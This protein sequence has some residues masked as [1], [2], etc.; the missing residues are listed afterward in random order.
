MYVN[1]NRIVSLV[2]NYHLLLASLC[3]LAVGDVGSNLRF[4]RLM[5]SGSD[6]LGRLGVWLVSANR[7]LLVMILLTEVYLQ[8]LVT[9]QVIHIRNHLLLRQLRKTF[10]LTN[11]SV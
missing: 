10:L 8:T 3:L 4:A 7:H 6:D 11:L 2:V 5:A 9:V 1:A